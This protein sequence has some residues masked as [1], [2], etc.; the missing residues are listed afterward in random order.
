VVSSPPRSAW[1]GPSSPAPA[2][3]GQIPGAR[4]RRT[5]GT[6]YENVWASRRSS[7]AFPGHQTLPRKIRQH[8]GTDG[9]K[10]L[11]VAGLFAG[12]GGLE[13]GLSRAGHETLLLSEV[14]DGARAVL[15]HH[16]P[17][18]DAD[19]ADVRKLERLP[20]DVDLLVAGFPCQDLSQVGPTAG[21]GGAKS[22][23]V[24]EVWRLLKVGRVP[25]VVL[26]N[27]PFMLWL[28]GGR[29]L[30]VIVTS[31]ESLGYRWA[32]RI[33][34][35]RAFG[36]PQRRERVFLVASTDGDP[37]SVLLV[38]DAGPPEAAVPDPDVACG[39]YW[40]E[41]NSGIGWAVDAVPPLKGGSGLG[42]PSA[43]A[44]FLPPARFVTPHVRDAE[45]L[46]GFPPGWTRPAEAR[47]RRRL[48]HRWKLVGNAVS[49]PV[50]TWLGERLLRPGTYDHDGDRELQPARRWP[51][52]AWGDGRGRRYSAEV[53]AWP[54][55]LKRK[56]LR[57]FLKE[58]PLP[59]GHKAAAGFL[60]R[61]EAS[62]L[63]KDQRFLSALRDYVQRTRA[64]LAIRA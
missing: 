54:K 3:T 29:A 49:V 13:L 61:L 43:P 55:R 27:V 60:S 2:N 16:F 7:T 35:T 31:L 64:R 57:D 26:E 19:T 41:G 11:R 28:H 9:G 46:Q 63:R 25:W 18:A 39:F 56:A 50:S 10:P 37:R 12:I 47:S 51:R 14:D 4:L 1:P 62:T 17:H 24:A 21:I 53:S 42:I 44:I 15:K 48:G 5:Q 34:D 30:D 23:L 45:R 20:S 36:L 8:A 59:L 52:A 6:E 40:T 32:Y 33:V 58:T 38:D 22:G